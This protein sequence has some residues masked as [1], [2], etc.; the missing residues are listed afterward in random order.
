MIYLRSLKSVR[1]FN[2]MHPMN[3]NP[4]QG[5]IESIMYISANLH[6]EAFHFHSSSCR[7]NMYL[8]S[9]QMIEILL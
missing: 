6:F 2:F 8:P 5:T 4:T 3:E 9:L 1:Q 7:E